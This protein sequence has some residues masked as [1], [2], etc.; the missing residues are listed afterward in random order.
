MFS[1]R[2]VQYS[3]EFTINVWRPAVD[4]LPKNMEPSMVQYVASPT[5]PSISG[6]RVASHSAQC[7]TVY[8]VLHSTHVS[9]VTSHIAQYSHALC[10]LPHR[11]LPWL[12]CINNGSIFSPVQAPPPSPTRYS[13]VCDS[14][15]G[16]VSR[17]LLFYFIL[18]KTKSVLFV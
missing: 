11:V 7:C 6:S 9:L 15:K 14:V 16:T 3:Q 8:S 12:L 18:L 1:Q 17:D 2:Y 10:I 4:S 5:E 13:H